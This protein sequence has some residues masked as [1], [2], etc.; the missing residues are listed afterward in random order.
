MAKPVEVLIVI[1]DGVPVRENLTD[2]E[3]NS[4]YDLLKEILMNLSILDWQDM[5]RILLAKLE[6][7]V[8]TRLQQ[9]FAQI[10]III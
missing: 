7:Q 6:R 9:V 8:F 1:E 5:T 2:T 4:L 3:N 10:I